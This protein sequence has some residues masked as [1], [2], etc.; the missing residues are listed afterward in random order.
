MRRTWRFLDRHWVDTVLTTSL[1]CSCLLETKFGAS[2]VV[3]Q[4]SKDGT[5]ITV[6]ATL[7]GFLI[8][9]LTILFALSDHAALKE[10]AGTRAY[11]YVHRAFISAIWAQVVA[12][13][14]SAV[15]QVTPPAVWLNR[16]L[17]TVALVAVAMLFLSVF[18]L[19]LIVKRVASEKK[20]RSQRV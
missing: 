15:V 12:L 6:F 1:V 20:P 4:L 3:A 10:V 14:V 7:A 16:I 9:G 5:F 13:V 2:S 17:L 19:S 11:A 18:F 8:T